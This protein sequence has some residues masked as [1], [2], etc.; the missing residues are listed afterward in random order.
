[1]RSPEVMPNELT[2]NI[3]TLVPKV[4]WLKLRVTITVTNY[5]V[6]HPYAWGAPLTE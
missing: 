6:V 1:M 3:G 5:W 4:E 2:L